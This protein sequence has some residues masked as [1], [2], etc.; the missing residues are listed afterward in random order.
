MNSSS[1]SGLKIL[2]R[3]FVNKKVFSSL[4]VCQ[5]ESA[6]PKS[7]PK[8]DFSSIFLGYARKAEPNGLKISLISQT[9]AVMIEIS[10]R[11]CCVFAVILRMK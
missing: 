11:P 4:F 1:I 7:E 5:T 2:F 8:L 3:N 9:I 6:G 10:V